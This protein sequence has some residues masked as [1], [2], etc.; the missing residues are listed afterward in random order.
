MEED[1]KPPKK[2]IPVIRKE[3]NN[4]TT[5]ID[6]KNNFLVDPLETN[7]RMEKGMSKRLEEVEEVQEKVQHWSQ[8]YDTTV[9]I[10]PKD[11]S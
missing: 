2:I 9:S 1:N 7:N 10:Y 5:Q 6:G 11:S 4:K 8:F 3:E